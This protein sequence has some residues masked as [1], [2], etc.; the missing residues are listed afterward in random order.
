MLD[1]DD[2]DDAV[3]FVRVTED[4]APLPADSA[5]IVSTSSSNRN[6]FPITIGLVGHVAQTGSGLLVR[7]TLSNKISSHST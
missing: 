2:E 7:S 4:S 3:K 5:I 6:H 1:D